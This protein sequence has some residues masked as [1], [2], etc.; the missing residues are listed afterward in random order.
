MFEK[1]LPD[2]LHDP[3]NNLTAYDKRIYYPPEIVYYRIAYNGCKSRF[4]AYLDLTNVAAV[5]IVKCLS[6]VAGALVKTGVKPRR[7]TSLVK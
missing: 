7:K 1:R 4:K 2:A 5:R 3:T 6:F